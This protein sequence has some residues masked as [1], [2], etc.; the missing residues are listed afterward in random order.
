M[1]QGPGLGLGPGLE[2]NTMTKFKSCFYGTLP[3]PSSVEGT[4][5]GEGFG[6]AVAACDINRD[7]LDDI[8]VSAP[9]FAS[10]RQ[11]LNTGKVYVLIN[12]P[13]NPTASFS[14]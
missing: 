13:S 12:N 11:N 2:N 7:G 6:S 9:T 5:M 1:G 4:Q 14:R 3:Q 10:R 8:I